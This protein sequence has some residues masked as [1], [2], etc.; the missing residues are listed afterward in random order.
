[1]NI[2]FPINF[3]E[4]FCRDHLLSRAKGESFIDEYKKFVYLAYVTKTTQ[5]PSEEVDLVWHYHMTHTKD[6][7][8]FSST[9]MERKIFSHSPANGTEEDASS[10]PNIYN[11]TLNYIL[12]Y[13]GYV[14]PNA[15]PD[16]HIRFNQK[17]KWYN[18]HSLIQKCPSWNSGNR[19]QNTKNTAYT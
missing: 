12:S 5:C 1:Q 11:S 19:Y 17:F 14:N 4:N 16:S 13:F 2:T 6:Y 10:Y 7:L 3:L 9:K 8:D 18:H 15:W